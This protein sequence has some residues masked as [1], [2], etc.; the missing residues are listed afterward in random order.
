MTENPFRNMMFPDIKAKDSVKLRDVI[1]IFDKMRNRSLDLEDNDAVKICLLVLLELGFL[2]H[3]L[4]HNITDKMLKLIEHLSNYM[5]I[6]GHPSYTCL[7]RQVVD[8]ENSEGFG[9][10]DD[11]TIYFVEMPDDIK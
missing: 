6:G 10:E 2:G 7:C 5:D 11:T 3:K 9:L 1:D 4:S 8:G